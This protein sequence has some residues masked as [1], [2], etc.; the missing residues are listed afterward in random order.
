L[1]HTA[2]SKEEILRAS[3]K[4]ASEEGLKSLNIRSIAKECG[5]SVGCVYRY[6]PSKADLIS[7]TVGKIWEHIFHEAEGCKTPDDFRECVRWIFRCIRSGCT[8][9][10]SFFLQHA[11]AFA[12]SEK[13]E[14]RRAMD[15]Y[16]GHIREALLC[17]LHSDPAARAGVFD[18][19]FA[20]KAFVGFVLDNLLLLGAKQ[21]PSCDY[22]IRLIE[23]LLY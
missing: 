12:E 15:Q 18:S 22:L 3:L 23:K 1:N 14:G 21:A 19:A 4:F 11:S 6:F 16:L 7:A 8:E 13:A 9:Y 2:T 17:A 5:V 10:P 20:P